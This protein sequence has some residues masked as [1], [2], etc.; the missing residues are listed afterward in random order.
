MLDAQGVD[1][2]PSIFIH[3]AGPEGK[4]QAV[5]LSAWTYIVE[6]SADF[7]NDVTTK[8]FGQR[9]SALLIETGKAEKICTA[10]F[11]PQEMTTKENG[12]VWILGQPL[13]YSV[14]VAYDIGKDGHGSQMAFIK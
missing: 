3:V 12:P 9:P 10:S 1:E 14:S 2:I 5:E 11:G 13:F 6:T 8:I 7:L 4:P